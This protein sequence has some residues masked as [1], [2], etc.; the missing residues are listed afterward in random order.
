VWK[1]DQ[2][3]IVEP[4]EVPKWFPEKAGGTAASH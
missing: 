2:Q 4:G 1:V 3:I